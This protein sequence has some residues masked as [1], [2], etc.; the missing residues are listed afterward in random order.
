MNVTT[1]CEL[2]DAALEMSYRGAALQF[3]AHDPAFCRAATIERIALLQHALVTQADAFKA[4]AAAYQRS[5]DAMLAEHGMGITGDVAGA[6]L[7]YA[8][9]SLGAGSLDDLQAEA[10]RG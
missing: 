1:R 3:T 9:A 10:L 8:V 2:C 6:A 4:A 5:V 7:R